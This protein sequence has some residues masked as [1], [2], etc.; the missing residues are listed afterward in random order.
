MFYREKK[1]FF[2]LCFYHITVWTLVPYISNKNLPL[3][4]IEHLTWG[5]DF[6]W[7]YDKH[8]PLTYWILGIVYKIF[9]NKDF[10]FYLLSQIFIV[11]TLVVLWKI[12][13][14]FLEKREKLISILIL[15]GIVFFNFETPQ[16]NVNICLLPIWAVTIYFFIKSIKDNKV[17]N[18]IFFGLFSG[19]GIL[20]KYIF[21]YLLASLC[22]YIL[23]IYLK[24][25]KYNFFYS[26]IVF[27]IVIFFHVEWI[28]S[29][30]FETLKYILFRTGLN[31]Y[32]YSNH[33]L[34]PIIVI[35]KQL[36]IL[37]PFFILIYLLIYKYKNLN[38]KDISFKDNK[39]IIL[40]FSFVIPIL[41]LIATSIITAAKIRSFWFIPFYTLAGIATVNLI[42]NKIN[43]F[44]LKNFYFFLII[45]LILTPLLYSLRSIIKDSRTGYDGKTLT[46]QVETEWKKISNDPISNIGFSA[47]YAGNLSYHLDYNTK[48]F[49][50]ED[51]NFYDAPAIIISRGVGKKLCEIQNNKILSRKEIRDNYFTYVQPLNLEKD[52]LK[53]KKI[54][55]LYRKIADHDICFIISNK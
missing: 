37:I 14:F 43:F 24:K 10:A 19:L 51:Q 48:T 33:V 38:K 16:F 17:Y 31:E 40:F 7:G 45:I 26:L 52:F 25:K 13:N 29:S 9:G 27:I 53:D 55:I 49:M 47:W 22:L 28:L 5:K 8:P 15:E 50:K 18:W 12:S 30:N 34:N 2:L 41:L 36:I 23:I 42:K 35:S 54:K 20:T 32:N 4:T 11:L 21:L 6:L 44:N 46:S 1:I 3:D 39:N